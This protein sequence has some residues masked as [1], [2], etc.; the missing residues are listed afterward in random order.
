MEQGV[1]R[2]AISLGIGLLAFLLS[3]G[4]QA[5]LGVAFFLGLLAFS[6]SF[7]GFF[8]KTVNLGV[9]CLGVWAASVALI[10]APSAKSASD[11]TSHMFNKTD[12]KAAKGVMSTALEGVTAAKAMASNAVASNPITAKLIPSVPAVPASTV[13]P[14]SAQAALQSLKQLEEVCA[15]GVLDAAACSAARAKLLNVAQ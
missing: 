8:R 3:L 7:S 9:F 14:G 4:V 5:G 6:T 2:F 12:G 15:T 10:D 13:R 11:W 1:I